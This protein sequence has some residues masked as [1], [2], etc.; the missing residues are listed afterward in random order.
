[1]GDPVFTSDYN[2]WRRNEF[3][4]GGHRPPV[5]RKALENFFLVVPLHFF[6]SK[7][8][9]SRFGERFRD[10]WSVSCLQFFYLLAPF[11]EPFVKVGE[12]LRA[13][14]ESAP[15]SIYNVP[16][17]ANIS[18]R[19]LRNAILSGE[20]SLSARTRLNTESYDG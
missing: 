20:S 5:R 19:A 11:A 14:M 15:L 2:Q 13:Y 9:I 10:V 18:G 12:A 1:L 4:S 7:S 3:E 8:T 16:V 17:P 6:G